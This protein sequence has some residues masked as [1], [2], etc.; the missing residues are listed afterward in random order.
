MFRQISH[1]TLNICIIVLICFVSSLLF[2][3]LGVLVLALVSALLAT[4]ILFL[5]ICCV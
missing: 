5:G 4:A 3:F 1:R 2:T